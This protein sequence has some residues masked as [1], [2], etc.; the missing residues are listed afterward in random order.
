LSN[1]KTK[2]QSSTK[3]HTQTHSTSL[4]LSLSLSKQTAFCVFVFRIPKALRFRT[5][6]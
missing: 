4:S 3:T 2:L 1:P 5:T 6:F